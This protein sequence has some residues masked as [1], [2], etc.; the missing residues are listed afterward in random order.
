MKEETEDFM[1]IN[2]YKMEIVLEEKREVCMLCVCARACAHA[3]AIK[4]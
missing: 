4:L 1:F 2:P 3:H